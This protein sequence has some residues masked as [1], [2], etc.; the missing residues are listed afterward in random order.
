MINK[1][2]KLKAIN[3]YYYTSQEKK[4]AG[5]IFKSKKLNLLYVKDLWKELGCNNKIYNCNYNLD[6]SKINIIEICNAFSEYSTATEEQV[7]N[8]LKAIPQYEVQRL[9]KMVKQVT[10]SQGKACSEKQFMQNLAEISYIALREGISPPVLYL[11]AIIEA[12]NNENKE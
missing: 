5:D 10:I 9:G 8:E 11:I 3:F 6:Y 2:D 12:K 7:D 1:N 4:Q